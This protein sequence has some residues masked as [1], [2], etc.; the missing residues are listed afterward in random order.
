MVKRKGL[1][2]NCQFDSWPLKVRNRL[3]FLVWT[4]RATYPWNVLDKGYNFGLDFTSIRGL[5]TKLW[6]SKVARVPTSRILGFPL[7]S[8]ETKW[9][10]GVGPMARHR[11]YYKG[12]GGGLPQ[13]RA[14]VNVVSSCLPMVRPCTKS[15]P[16]MH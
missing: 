10:L 5:H 8:P 2:S 3:D 12:E 9:H 1:E 6:A 15:A 13:V 7:G 14:M 16:I 11:K 4:W